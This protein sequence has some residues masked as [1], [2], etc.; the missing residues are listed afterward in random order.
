LNFQP[1]V[2]HQ[3]ISHK[4][5]GAIRDCARKAPDHN[6]PVER[7]KMADRKRIRNKPHNRVVKFPEAKGKII[8]GMEVS[9]SPDFNI[10]EVVFEDKTSI[11]FEIVPCF[12]I[13]P[14][15]VNWK[16]GNYKP[17]KRWKPVHSV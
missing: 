8:A 16:S 12:Q 1:I 7:R 2:F 15:L 13:V 5:C 6:S 14:E 11:G 10:I 9:I 3:K 4:D 17:M